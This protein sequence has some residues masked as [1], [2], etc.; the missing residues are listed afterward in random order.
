MILEKTDTVLSWKNKGEDGKFYPV[1]M[2]DNLEI[3]PSALSNHLANQMDLF[4]MNHE[5]QYGELISELLEIFL[6]PENATAAE[7][8]EAKQNMKKYADYRTYLSFDMEQMVRGET[9]KSC[10]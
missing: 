10:I 9:G 6:P 2:D 4:T 5:E 3:S 7:L 8:E 1:F